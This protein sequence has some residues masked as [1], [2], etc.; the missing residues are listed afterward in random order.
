MRLLIF[1]YSLSSGGAERVTTNLANHWATRGWE[2]IVVTLAPRDLDFYELHPAIERIALDQ[3]NESANILSGVWNNLRRLAALRRVLREQRPDVALGMM[4]TASVLAVLANLGSPRKVMISE[5]IH[6][7]SLPVGTAWDWLRRCIYPWAARVVALTDESCQWL[8][9]HVPG[10][11][12]VVI[13]NPVPF[14][15]PVTEP[16]LLPEQ[17]VSGHR[18]I[19]LAVGRLAK[20]KGFD[21]LIKAFAGM[22]A[23]YTDWDLVI[24]G[25]GSKRLDLE[26]RVIALQLDH[27]VK[28]PGRAGNIADWYRRADLYVMSSRFEG[29]PNTLVEAM[30]HGC[31]AVSF[32]CETGPR[33]IIRH[34]VDGLLVP[35]GDVPALTEALDQ[36][37]GDADLRT[38]YAARAV[39]ARERFS[40]ERIAGMWETLFEELR[41]L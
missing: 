20:Q 7:P 35:A 9:T 36:L 40:I 11:R 18:R 26:A 30:A 17:V 12:V 8:Q 19:V 25:E 37:M 38:R 31:P 13:P 2:I 10:C 33:D 4:T 3:A 1:I 28:L 24:L 34:K 23:A 32:D 27:R 14:P 6:P 22:A 15:L 41:Y 21:L 16:V 39:E 29:F 5:R